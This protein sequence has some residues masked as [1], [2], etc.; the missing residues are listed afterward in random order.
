MTPSPIVIFGTGGHAREIHAVIETMPEFKFLGWLDGN[1][2]QHGVNIHGVK[3]LGGVEW[4]AE[5]PDVEVMVGIGAPAPRRRVIHQI[6]AAGHAAWA[7]IVSP[8]AKVGPRIELGQGV[9]IAPGV[10]CTTDLSIGDFAHLNTGALLSHDVQIGPY[11]MIAPRA[12]L[13]GNVHIG[14]GA[15]IGLNSSII[16]GR[17][18]GSWSVVGAQACVRTDLPANCVAVGVPAEIIKVRDAGW[19]DLLAPPP[20]RR[21]EATIN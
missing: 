9:Y 15:D 8:D 6:Q 2:A 13:A 4:L 19:H 20:G 1:P 17:T 14:E 12:A 11:A 18:V 5:R 16:Q 3:V 10:I 7:T 21:V